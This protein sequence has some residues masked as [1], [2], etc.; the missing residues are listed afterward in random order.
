MEKFILNNDLLDKIANS[1]KITEMEK[2]A[3]MK[4]VA[5]MTKSEQKEL[6]E[7]L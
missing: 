5:Y 3:F 2:L 1:F 4:Y 6:Y 7:L